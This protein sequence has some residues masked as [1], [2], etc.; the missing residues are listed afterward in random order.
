[1]WVQFSL[2]R[3]RIVSEKSFGNL[4]LAFSGQCNS[5]PFQLVSVAHWWYHNKVSDKVGSQVGISLKVL[6]IQLRRY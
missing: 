3:L 5:W 2:N 6:W 1:M 4:E